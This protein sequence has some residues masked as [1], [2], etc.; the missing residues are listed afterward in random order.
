MSV[1]EF[2]LKAFTKAGFKDLHFSGSGTNEKLLSGI[3]NKVLVEVDPQF[4]RLGEVPHL[5]GDCSKIERELD[6]Q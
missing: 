4:F 5:L 1:R 3:D 6:W 2:L